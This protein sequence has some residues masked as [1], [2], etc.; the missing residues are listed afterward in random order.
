MCDTKKAIEGGG[1]KGREDK[2]G[3]RT[4]DG[5]TVTPIE[6]VKGTIT[7]KGHRSEEKK[8]KKTQERRKE[9]KEDRQRCIASGF[10]GEDCGNLPAMSEPLCGKNSHAAQFET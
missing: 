5:K 8:K 7:S 2:E 1:E 9:R 3:G 10:Q 4:R 6:G